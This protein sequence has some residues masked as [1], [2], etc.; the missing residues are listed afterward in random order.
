MIDYQPFNPFLSEVLLSTIAGV[1]GIVAPTWYSHYYSAITKLA[2]IT[3][4]YSVSSPK[5]NSI[6]S[7][8]CASDD[9]SH[10][11]VDSI[12]ARH[13]RLMV[14]LSKYDK[15]YNTLDLLDRN[16]QNQFYSDFV[17]EMKNL[18]P[19]F[20]GVELSASSRD[21]M[22]SKA[23]DI[24]KIAKKNI[25]KTDYYNCFVKDSYDL[26]TKKY[27]ISEENARLLKDYSTS[28]S[29]Q[30]EK[31]DYD[32]LERY[33]DDLNKVIN[34]SN[35]DKSQKQ[36]IVSVSQISINSSLCWKE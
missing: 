22:I 3:W 21:E 31:L 24:L 19:E 33:A 30:C 23:I 18:Y 20:Q 5:L 27:K 12:G 28:L 4:G 35:L 26:I 10:S 1:F 9:M 2:T 25:D 16:V 13:N 11:F 32:D 14:N 17:K 6:S 8:R 15:K 29:L 7:I 36:A 34:S